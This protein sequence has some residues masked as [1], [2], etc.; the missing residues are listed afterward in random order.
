[1]KIRQFHDHEDH[2]W[3]IIF[4]SEEEAQ[5]AKDFL[6]EMLSG[7][8]LHRDFRMDIVENEGTYTGQS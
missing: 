2:F 5:D 1:M 8:R 3:G 7:R 6:E 4:D